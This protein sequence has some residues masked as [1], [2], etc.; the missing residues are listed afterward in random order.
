M[1]LYSR[2]A[3]CAAAATSALLAD[4]L[5]FTIDPFSLKGPFLTI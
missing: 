1:N 4:N 3:F 2:I 5:T